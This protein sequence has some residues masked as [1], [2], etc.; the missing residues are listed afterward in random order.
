MVKGGKNW[1]TSMRDLYVRTCEKPWV[2]CSFS[3]IHLETVYNETRSSHFLLQILSTID[4]KS[5]SPY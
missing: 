4:S 1:D 3:H 2:S 5:T